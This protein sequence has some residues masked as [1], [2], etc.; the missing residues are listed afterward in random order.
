MSASPYETLSSGIC[1]WLQ[2]PLLQL[3]AAR[4]AGRLGHGWLLAG[5]RGVGKIN[6]ALLAARRLLEG[7]DGDVRLLEAGEAATAMAER[8]EPTDHHP[9]LHWAFPEPRRNTLTVEQIREAAQALSLTSLTGQARVLVLE[10]ADAMTTAAANALLKTLE[11]PGANTYLLLISHQPGRLPATIR[12]RCQS[13]SVRC[14][15]G[16]EALTWLNGA[17]KDPGAVDWIPLLEAARGVPFRAI[18]YHRSGF[19][20]YYKELETEFHKISI[21]RTDPQAV[22]DKWLAGDTEAALSWLSA[23]LQSIIRVRLA[24]DCAG[25]RDLTSSDLWNAW[26][27]FSTRFLFEQQ[28]NAELLLGQLGGG[29]NVELAV[30]AILLGFRPKER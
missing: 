21:N 11:E 28:K 10:P 1:P 19:S 6:L 2:A 27:P 4:V 30:R 26:K 8:H 7:T 12:S 5:P 14:P 23:R 16:A 15:A 9:D 18:D 25:G 29:I 24:P 20:N 13:L 3:E 17:G 22:A